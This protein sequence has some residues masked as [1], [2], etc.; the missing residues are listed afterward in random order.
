MPTL[1]RNKHSHYY[2]RSNVSYNVFPSQF[3]EN[4]Q[5][6]DDYFT[7]RCQEHL[8]CTTF[9]GSYSLA[10]RILISPPYI[11][12]LS[13]RKIITISTPINNNGEYVGDFAV[14]IYLDLYSVFNDKEL[15]RTDN[16]VYVETTIFDHPIIFFKHYVYTKNSLRIIEMYLI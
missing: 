2:F 6:P 4:Y 11:D 14:D 9:S 10:D 5:L 16:G 13:K 3:V 15:I 12:D 8:T 7:T 1:F